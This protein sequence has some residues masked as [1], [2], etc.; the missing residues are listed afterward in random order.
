M[1]HSLRKMQ[2]KKNSVAKT[3]LVALVEI[4]ER[5]KKIIEN[6]LM[7]VQSE[8]FDNNEKKKKKRQNEYEKK[9]YGNV[10]V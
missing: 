6:C 5:Q 2:C 9:K 3:F 4:C 8:R 7:L 1:T 10:F